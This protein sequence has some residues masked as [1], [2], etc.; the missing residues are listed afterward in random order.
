MILHH[1]YFQNYLMGGV[2]I[3]LSLGY[4]TFM[5]SLELTTKSILQC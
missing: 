1:I 5:F 3:D 4:I 2:K